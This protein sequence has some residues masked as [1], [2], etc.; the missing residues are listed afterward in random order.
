VV[1]HCSVLA[2]CM[3]QGG[4]SPWGVCPL[5]ICSL[6]RQT[7]WFLLAFCVSGG[8]EE[9]V[10][11]QPNSALSQLTLAFGAWGLFWLHTNFG[12]VIS[13]YM[14]KTFGILIGI[15]LNLYI[16]LTFSQY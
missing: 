6:C 9:Y 4:T 8:A 12:V 11:G 15:A 14:K 7:G 16:S 2:K 13:I 10:D 1:V 5:G 3:Q